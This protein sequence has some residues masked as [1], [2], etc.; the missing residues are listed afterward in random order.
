M[1]D[2]D[3]ATGLFVRGLLKGFGADV[4]QDCVDKSTI[5][6]THVKK[7]IDAFK[8]GDT[9]TAMMF[10][11]QAVEQDLPTILKSCDKSKQ[12]VKEILKALDQ[13]P[14]AKSL[15]FHIGTDIVVNGRD[16]TADIAS[17]HSS[18]ASGKYEDA[19][20]TL[21]DAVNKVLIGS[22]FQLFVGQAVDPDI[23]TGLF[24][25]GLLK[26]FGADVEQDCVDKSTVLDG[27][28]RQ[29]LEAFKKG[30]SATAIDLVS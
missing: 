21:G 13:F 29:A 26:G 14:D 11:A 3:I 8:K 2:P 19:G 12:Q 15:V 10:L 1:G 17:M 28:L 16:I 24:V 25:R 18:F 7:A 22:A 30:D 5:M 27:H 4:E 20:K 23:A 9:T 6:D